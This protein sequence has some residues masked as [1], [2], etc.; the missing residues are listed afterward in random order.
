MFCRFLPD[1]KF[2]LNKFRAIALLVLMSTCPSGR[3]LRNPPR[4]T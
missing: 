4:Q 2:Y 3:S 1:K